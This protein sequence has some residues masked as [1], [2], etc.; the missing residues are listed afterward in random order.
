MALTSLIAPLN[1]E[2][3]KSRN[4]H[5]KNI[6]L[7]L[8]EEEMDLK[9]TYFLNDETFIPHQT[10]II[11]RQILMWLQ[12][13]TRRISTDVAN[14]CFSFLD[15]LPP[16]LINYILLEEVYSTDYGTVVFDWEKDEDNVFSFELG[17][18]KVGY[19]IEVDGRDQKQVDHAVLHEI[20]P[21]VIKDLS[22]FLEV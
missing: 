8:G 17:A 3:D 15:E 1:P 7:E 11:K 20:L 5:S 10:D 6:I 9:S 22:D 2:I 4:L 21:Q 14:Q 19:F 13:E 16:S 18:D 12:S